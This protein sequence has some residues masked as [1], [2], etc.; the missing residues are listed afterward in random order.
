[1]GLEIIR[2]KPMTKK[3]NIIE[4][5]WGHEEIWAQSEKYVAKI[6]FIK[7]GNRLSLQ[8]HEVKEE[9]IRV[10]SGTLKLITKDKLGS[11]AKTSYLSVGEVFHITPGLIHR[12]CAAEHLGD[13]TLVEVST[14][15]IEDVVR[16][17]DDYGR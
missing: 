16:L 17:E 10:L 8:Y 2:G 14:T 6:L 7:A 3:P 1:M 12:F 13:V 11:P 5:P 4:K 9:T 15:E